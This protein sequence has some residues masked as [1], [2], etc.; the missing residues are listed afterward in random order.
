MANLKSLLDKALAEDFDPDNPN[1]PKNKFY[2]CQVGFAHL[3]GYSG[4]SGDRCG[5]RKTDF[6]WC[7]EP[8]I[9]FL[10]IEMWGAGG[11]AAGVCCCM[12]G[13]AAGAGAY[14]RLNCI[15]VRTCKRCY[16][17]CIGPNSCCSP[18][19]ECGYR[20]CKTYHVDGCGY[21]TLQDGTPVTGTCAE[22]GASGCSIFQIFNCLDGNCN[23]GCNGCGVFLDPRYENCCSCYFNAD[24]G[25]PGRLGGIAT[26]N[27]DNNSCWYRA[28]VPIAPLMDQCGYRWDMLRFC[29]YN[30]HGSWGNCRAG[31]GLMGQS[32]ASHRGT[33]GTGGFPGSALGGNCYCGGTGRPGFI[34]INL[35]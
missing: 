33:P 25:M 20:G 27:K 29:N 22:G 4:G 16:R 17:F 34:R 14:A 3:C 31:Q 24:F 21:M 28:Y 2:N 13:F 32:G 18:V 11:G 10:Q 6:C 19:K 26:H 9:N 15:D 30:N 35:F 1:I 5:E 8:S 7:P 12:W 23:Q